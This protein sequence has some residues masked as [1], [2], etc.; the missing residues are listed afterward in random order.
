MVLDIRKFSGLD[1]LNAFVKGR[2]RG[3]TDLVKTPSSLYLHGL[4]LIFATPADTVTFAASPAAP[5]VP[6]TRAQVKAQIEAQA[7]GV[8]VNF[9]QGA[10]ELRADPAGTLVL[11]KDGTANALLGFPTKADTTV[12][13]VNPPGGASPIFISVGPEGSQGTY[14]LTIDVT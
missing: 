4:T 3:S 12:R 1:S 8:L 10:I 13:P 5:Q 11:D 2:L 14:L 7:A 6:L 9:V